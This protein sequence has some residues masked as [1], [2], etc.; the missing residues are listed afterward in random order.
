MLLYFFYSLSGEF[1][2]LHK[3]QSIQQEV[4][5]HVL[6]KLASEMIDVFR[7][8]SSTT[9]NYVSTTLNLNLFL[10]GLA[11]CEIKTV[12]FVI[13]TIAKRKF[14]EQCRSP[15]GSFTS[16]IVV[17]GFVLNPLYGYCQFRG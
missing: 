5:L 8:F 13:R 7:Y 1:V 14:T 11:S 12:Q 3:Q 10:G 9:L 2:G 4:R 17:K 6:I 16:H 15:V